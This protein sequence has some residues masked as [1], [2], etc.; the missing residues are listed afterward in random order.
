MEDCYSCY[1]AE[2]GR[3][4]EILFSEHKRYVRVGVKQSAVFHHVQDNNQNI[5]WPS[6]KYVYNS[7]NKKMRIIVESILTERSN[8]FN[9]IF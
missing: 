6:T 4:L 9:N 2:T 7:N 5:E 3:T 8:N 1:V